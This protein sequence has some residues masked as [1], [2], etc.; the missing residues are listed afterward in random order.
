MENKNEDRVRAYIE[1]YR[2]LMSQVGDEAV[3]AAI[4]EQIGKDARVE[5]MAAER[6]GRSEWR[7]HDRQSDGE[8]AATP[9]QI[10]W[11]KR[12]GIVVPSGTTK[13]AASAMIDEALA[14]QA[15]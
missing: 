9:K 1:L 13:A 11:L 2:E 12:A 15:R 8:Q 3:A 7:P 6:T 14:Q 5:R 4:L 10:G